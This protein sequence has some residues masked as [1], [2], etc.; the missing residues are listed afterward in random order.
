MSRCIE[1]DI[2]GQGGALAE[3]DGRNPGIADAFWQKLPLEA[4]ANLWDEEVYFEIPL[5]EQDENPTP[6]AVQGDISYWSPGQA[7]CI[8]YENG[9]AVGAIFI[10][11]R[12]GS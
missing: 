2:H 11:P 1:I 8:W 9:S 3:L 10:L 6:S 5:A 12:T 4:R 7:F